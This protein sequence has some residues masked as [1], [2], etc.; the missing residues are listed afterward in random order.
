M[1]GGSTTTEVQFRPDGGALIMMVL[2]IV[3]SCGLGVYFEV[4]GY[5]RKVDK[6]VFKATHHTI[7]KNSIKYLRLLLRI[8]KVLCS[9][10][11]SETGYRD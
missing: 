8:M 2:S 1:N 7:Q 3:T 11:G 9:N 4:G 6:Y 5:L 10:L